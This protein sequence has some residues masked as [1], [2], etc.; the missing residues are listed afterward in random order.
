[1]YARLENTFRNMK[2]RC[3]D[4]LIFECL[5]CLSIIY[6]NVA[7]VCTVKTLEA[8]YFLINIFALS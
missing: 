7:I 5:K 2:M 8:S 6:H 3:F 1:M 4:R